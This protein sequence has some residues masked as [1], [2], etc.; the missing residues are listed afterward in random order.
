MSLDSVREQTDDFFS[1]RFATK[2]QAE[3]GF[4]PKI[5]RPNHEDPNKAPY[6]KFTYNESESHNA[7]IGGQIQRHIGFVQVDVYVKENT[8]SKDSNIICDAIVTILTN[9]ELDLG[10]S[11]QL[12]YR[13][14]MTQEIGEE[15]SFYRQMVRVPYFRDVIS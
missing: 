8:G 4:V 13:V 1:P 14:G 12:T 2:M 10:N 11:E 5:I 6:I 3:L 9:Q 15:Q 7:A